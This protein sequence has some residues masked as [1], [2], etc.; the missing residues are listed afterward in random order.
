MYPLRILLTG[1]DGSGKSTVACELVTAIRARHGKAMLLSTPGGR[2]TMTA[3]WGTLGR[4]PSVRVQDV[5]ETGLR[6]LHAFLNEVRAAGFD[7]VVVVDRGLVCQLAYREARGLPR[8][9]V[10]PWLQQTLPA[11]DITVHFDLPVETALARVRARATD[12]E[13]SAGLRVLDAGYRRLPE[14]ADFVLVDATRPTGTV[15]ESLLAL[16][17]RN[18]PPP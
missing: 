17:D 6:V 14:F 3:W 13:T 9:T 1:I 7:G 5:L 18:R 16:I 12:S 4:T 11:P 8:G 2:R 10:L 15:L